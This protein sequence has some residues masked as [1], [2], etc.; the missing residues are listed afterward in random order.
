ML[1]GLNAFFLLVDRPEVYR[2][3]PDPK[4]PS[5]NLGSGSVWTMLG[6]A[7]V[8]VLGVFSFRERGARASTPADAEDAR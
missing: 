3:P 1:G 2:L 5:R 6:A 4:L 8:A 7:L